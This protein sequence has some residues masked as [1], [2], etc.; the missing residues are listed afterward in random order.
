VN[1]LS[2]QHAENEPG[3]EASLGVSPERFRGNTG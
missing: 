2:F 1:K 3:S